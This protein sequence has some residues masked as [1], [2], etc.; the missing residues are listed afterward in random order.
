MEQVN[1]PMDEKRRRV[2]QTLLNIPSAYLGLTTLHPAAAFW[3]TGDCRSSQ[4]IGYSLNLPAYQRQLPLFWRS[5]S[6]RKPEVFSDL[7]ARVTQLEHAV[8]Y[9]NIH[10]R[11]Q[12]IL[13]LCAYLSACGNALRYQGYMTAALEYLNKA[14][15]IALEYGYDDE[16]VKALYVRGFTYFN[17]WTNW[18]QGE[19]ATD[20]VAALRDF[21]GASDLLKHVQ[22]RNV[23]LS[24]SLKGAILADGGR[25]LAYATHDRLENLKALHWVDRAGSLV[26]HSHFQHD[27]LFLR[28]DEEWYHIDKA[29]AL[30]SSGLPGLALQELEQVYQQG[31]PQARQRY[32]YATIIEAEA[33]I[34]KGWGEVG[35]VYLD[36]ALDALN[37][38]TSRRHLL[39]IVRIHDKLKQDTHYTTCT[40]VARL[41]GK[42][43]RI[44]YPELFL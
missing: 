20:L 22:E 33:Y 7:L 23:L 44:Q 26:S 40:D 1:L 32:L 19:G 12:T 16:Y 3:E 14:L 13:L 43:L 36:E 8:L 38:T 10:E 29:E 21:T 25:A 17:R 35:I 27:P 24:A 30:L 15:K 28:V 9:G 41:G 11:S 18:R 42:L 5:T 31:D 37:E 2:I 39:H 4:T 6:T 34:A